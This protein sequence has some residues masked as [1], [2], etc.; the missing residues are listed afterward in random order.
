M[1]AHLISMQRAT[2]PD[3]QSNPE[4]KRSD[5]LSDRI[6]E[7]LNIKMV[8]SRHH[9]PVGTNVRIFL[10]SFF[11]KEFR[12]HVDLNCFEYRPKIVE[13]FESF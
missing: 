1:V 7:T 8:E 2:P 12:I 5:V 13:N 9:I 4:W 10:W 3:Y 11:F 6:F